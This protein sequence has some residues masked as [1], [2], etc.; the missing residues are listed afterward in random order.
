MEEQ[1]LFKFVCVKDAERLISI[2]QDVQEL[3][4]ECFK[5]QLS[6]PLWE[7]L[8]LNCPYG[9]AIVFL[10]YNDSELIGHCGI[11]PQVLIDHKGNEIVYYL[12]TALMIDQRYRTLKPFNDLMGMIHS[13]I[14]KN[15]TFVIAFPNDQSFKPFVMMLRWRFITEYSIN[16]YCISDHPDKSLEKEEGVRSDFLYSQ[17]LDEKFIKWRGEINGLKDLALENG[18]IFYKESEGA[19]EL[20]DVVG[21]GFSYKDILTTLGYEKVNI[22]QCFLGKGTIKGLGYVQ[23]VG[24]PQRFCAYP[25]KTTLLDYNDI[26]PSLMLSDVF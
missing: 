26:K 23:T 25:E 10:A 19:L 11:I 17:R 20:L 4:K 18:R 24:I 21:D 15:N 13:H 8:Y 7:H 14:K 5:K 1:T 3:F 22:P 9:N 12:Q 16:Q 6:T 2:R